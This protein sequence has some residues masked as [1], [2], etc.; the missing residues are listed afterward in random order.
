MC[1]SIYLKF[2][3]KLFNNEKVDTLLLLT[4]LKSVNDNKIES[5]ITSSANLDLFG[6]FEKCKPTLESPLLDS[7]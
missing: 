6:R 2:S 5:T 7:V 3:F 4:N 1:L